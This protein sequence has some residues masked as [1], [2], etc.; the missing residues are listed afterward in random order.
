MFSVRNKKAVLKKVDIA[1]PKVLPP[2]IEDKTNEKSAKNLKNPILT[3][4]QENE[5]MKN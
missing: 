2:K 3:S 5:I 1:D 4:S